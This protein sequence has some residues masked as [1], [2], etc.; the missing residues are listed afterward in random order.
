MTTQSPK[1]GFHGTQEETY[2]VTPAGKVWLVQS[3]D[4]D[5]VSEIAALPS[6]AAEIPAG[7]VALD[8]VSDW[9]TQIQDEGGEVLLE[10]DD[11]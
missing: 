9:L 6:E 7:C 4:R 1:V 2:Y 5:G 10:G 3:P 11:R 8:E